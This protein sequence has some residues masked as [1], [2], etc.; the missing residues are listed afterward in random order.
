MGRGPPEAILRKLMRSYFKFNLNRRSFD[1]ASE[2]LPE[3]QA[4]W[5]KFGQFSN[6]TYTIMNKIDAATLKDENEFKSFKKAV[7][8]Y[9]ILMNQGIHKQKSKVDKKGS[10]NQ[11]AFFRRQ[12]AKYNKWDRL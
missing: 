11:G 5:E 3:L 12:Q 10:S 7:K 4:S 8:T 9:P 1:S 2:M 6:E